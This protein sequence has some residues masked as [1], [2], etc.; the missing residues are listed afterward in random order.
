ML[1]Q[2]F[3]DFLYHFYQSPR[4]RS[5]LTQEQVLID[6]CVSKVFGF[7][8]VQLGIS[9]DQ[10]ILKKSRVN[11]NF[12]I[13]EFKPNT[14]PHDFIQAD[15]D[16]L[17]ISKDSVDVVLLPHTLEAVK[18]PYHLLRQV[19]HMLVPEGHVLITG[20]NPL[21]C[22]I[23]RH[24]LGQDRKHFK[25]AN[26]VQ[27]KR[28]IDWLNVLGYDI[29]KI[30]YSSMSCTSSAKTSKLLKWL[31]TWLDNLGIDLG[32]VYCIL[33]Q[34]RVGSPTPVGLNW[35]LA[36]WLPI[37]KGRITASTNRTQTNVKRTQ[38]AKS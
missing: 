38:N 26:L 2:P 12:V 33:A 3:H 15:L 19:D 30:N 18:D 5:L 37:K 17:P 7:Y 16:Y 1:N 10:N 11:R 29:I 35:R 28:V 8:L 9:S 4:G 22:Q 20:F 32:N 31:E 14:L 27:E 6:S 24:R 34:K 21:G 25:Q 13:D 23:L 36:N